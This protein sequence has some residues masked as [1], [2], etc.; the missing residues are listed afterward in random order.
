LRPNKPL[1]VSRGQGFAQQNSVAHVSMLNA[2]V[3]GFDLRTEHP[4]LVL[5]EH[6]VPHIAPL[7]LC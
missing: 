3:K 5:V 4:R 7:A 2:I 1:I 6:Q